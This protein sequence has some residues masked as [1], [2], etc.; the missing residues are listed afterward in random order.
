MTADLVS[1]SIEQPMRP[2]PQLGARRRWDWKLV[3]GGALA[4]LVLAWILFFAGE[5]SAGAAI[6]EPGEFVVTLLDGL[7]FAGLY[8][9]VASG[10]TLIFGLMRTVNMAHGSLFLLAAYIAIEVQQRM[11]GKTRNIDR[12]RR[13]HCVVDRAAAHRCAA[14]PPSSG[15]VISAGV[16]ALEPGPGAASGA[17]HARHRR[18]PRRSDAGPLRRAGPVDDLAAGRHPLRRDLRSALRDQSA[19]HARRSRSSSAALLW[20]WLNRTRMGIVIRAGVDDQADGASARHQHQR[21]LRDHV[22][23][24]CVPR[25][26][27]RRDGRLVRRRRHRRRRAVAAA[28]RWSW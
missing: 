25:R 13:R 5:T 22:L 20:L 18:H 26:H 1:D 6:D 2:R 14:S 21:R 28:T 9:V 3:A 19:V 15:F 24:R 8:F 16:P 4:A 27:G 23:R 17:D 10:F 12:R 7:T 11:V